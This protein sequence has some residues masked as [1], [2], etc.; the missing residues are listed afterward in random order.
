MS[1]L[2]ARCSVLLVAALLFGGCGT[3]DNAFD[4]NAICSRYKSCFDSSFDVAA[5]GT[6]C[7]VASKGDADFTRRVNVCDACI[8]SRSCAAATF[9]CATSCVGVVP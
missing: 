9:S 2:L 5:C 1:A 8:D 7:R 3:V 4:C 6:R